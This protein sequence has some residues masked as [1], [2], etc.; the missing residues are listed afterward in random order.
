[1]I[2]CSNEER[3]CVKEW[4]HIKCIGMAAKDVPPGENV[5]FC[6]ECVEG[7]LG[8]LK[9]IVYVPWKREGR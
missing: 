4:Y 5:W 9:E 1:M 3:Y 7:R 8:R 6:K 2:Q